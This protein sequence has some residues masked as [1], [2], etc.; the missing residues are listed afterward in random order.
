MAQT[1]KSAVRNYLTALRDPSALRDD[2]K[3]A[4]LRQRLETTE[5]AAE[6]VQLRQQILD[7]ESPSLERFED[8]FVTHAKAWAEEQGVTAK[9]FEEEGVS[10][11][12]LR[13]AGFAGRRRGGTRR[14]ASTRASRSRV[15]ADEVRKAI[16]RG[17]FTIKTLQERSGA[18]PAVVRK[19][20][21]EEEANGRIEKTGTDPDHSGPGRA[22][23]LYRRL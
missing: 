4:D 1:A 23:T 19:V 8:E 11:Q 7:A 5:D 16:P 3:I 10:N 22:P 13:K 21:N 2:E 14:T 18:S 9:A 12:V 15:T 6:R 17:S 20:V